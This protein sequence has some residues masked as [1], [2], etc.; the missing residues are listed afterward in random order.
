MKRLSIISL[1]L[2]AVLISACAA[3]TDVRWII[4]ELERQDY[5]AIPADAVTM[6]RQDRG[7]SVPQDYVRL[8]EITVS[9]DGLANL[10]S[11]LRKEAG[12]LGANAIIVVEDS[13][14]A[15]PIEEVCQDV[16]VTAGAGGV[17]GAADAPSLV[18]GRLG[19]NC[20]LEQ[21]AQEREVRVMRVLAVHIP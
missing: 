9:T 16:D 5:P 15:R 13:R 12:K 6:F 8:A 1:A 17:G 21:A 2:S 4:P 11:T 14:P 20:A 18:G 19:L 10:T 3:K 7:E